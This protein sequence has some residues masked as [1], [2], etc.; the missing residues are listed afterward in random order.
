[1]TKIILSLLVILL[2][3]QYR[4]HLLR[5]QTMHTL[6]YVTQELGT[7]PPTNKL[8]IFGSNVCVCVCVCVYE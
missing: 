4:N 1:M 7:G 8:M 2:T 6:G 3:F 5:I